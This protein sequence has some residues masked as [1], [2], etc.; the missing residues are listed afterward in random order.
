MD[1]WNWEMV[2]HGGL[3]RAHSCR[4]ESLNTR[5]CVRV[6][7]VPMLGWNNG[8]IFRKNWACAKSHLTCPRWDYLDTRASHLWRTWYQ[9]RVK[10]QLETSSFSR[11]PLCDHFWGGKKFYRP[12]R[13]N[14]HRSSR[15]WAN[16]GVIWHFEH[17]LASAQNRYYHRI[18]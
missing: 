14:R 1:I 4:S 12:Y 11:A 7:Y 10:D 13:F 16:L 3:I 15:L 9:H 8:Y 5:T 17:S 2:Q 18:N 6:F